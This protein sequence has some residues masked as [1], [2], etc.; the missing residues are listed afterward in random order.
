MNAGNDEDTGDELDDELVESD[1][2]MVSLS[3]VDVIWLLFSGVL[4]DVLT[5]RQFRQ[6]ILRLSLE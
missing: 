6:T 5:H 1:E 2:V 3:D 4:V